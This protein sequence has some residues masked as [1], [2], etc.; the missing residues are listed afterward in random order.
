[1]SKT[2]ADFEEINR[3]IQIKVNEAYKK[4]HKEGMKY[5]KEI[6][7]G[8]MKEEY[9]RGYKDALEAK[10]VIALS[11][12]CDSLNEALERGR[13]EAWELAS[14]IVYDKTDGKIHKLEKIFGSSDLATIFDKNSFFSALERVKDMKKDATDSNDG[15]IKVGDEVR[16]ANTEEYGIVTHYNDKNHLYTALWKN[17]KSGCIYECCLHKTGRHFTSDL[18]NLLSMV[19]GED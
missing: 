8:A 13:K 2:M 12:H 5:R 19:Q 14:N 15:S 7:E 18:S 1:M 17:G 3:L 9:Q 10:E 16:F 6:T 11:A 4:G